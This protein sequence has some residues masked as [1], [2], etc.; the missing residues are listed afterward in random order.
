MLRILLLGSP[1]VLRDDQPV[2]I[3]RRIQRTLLFYL[4]CQ[5][6]PVGRQEL[7]ALFWPEEPDEVS[8]QR[9]REALSRLRGQLGN[10]RY[11]IISQDIVGLNPAHVS[12]DAQEFMQ[13]VAA[14]WRTLQ[15]IPNNLPLP[16]QVYQRM[17]AA[18]SLW[19]SP[20]FLAG[21][22]IHSTHEL[23]EWLTTTAHRLSTMRLQVIERL[24]YHAAAAGDLMQGI[25]WLDQ[26]LESDLLNESINTQILLWQRALGLRTQALKFCERIQTVFQRET[27][28]APPPG[29]QSL[30]RKIRE[31]TA[32]SMP[33][34]KNWP[35]PGRMQ[36]PFVG[37][38]GALQALTAAL[39]RG[40]AVL[41]SGEAG[42]GKTRLI[43]QFFQSSPLALRLLL[44]QARPGESQL[45][46]QPLIEMLRASILETE[47]RQ[48]DPIWTAALTPLLP[49]LNRL[50]PPNSPILEGQANIFE[51]LRQLLLSINADSPLLL[52]L[53]D[54]HWSDSATFDALEYL[55][56]R[57]TFAAQ[58]LLVLAARS[59]DPGPALQAFLHR[60]RKHTLETRD[61]RSLKS[62]EIADIARHILN[63]DPPEK[64]VR[65]LAHDSGGNP[66]FI[67]EILR[68][69]LEIPAADQTG[70][71]LATTSIK[72]IL[73]ERQF[74][75]TSGARLVLQTAAVIG[76]SFS[77]ELLERACALAPEQIVMAL[78][79]LERAQLIHPESGAAGAAYT[80]IHE[81][82]RDLLQK[83]LS[84]AR[85]RLL[86][87]RI[88]QILQQLPGEDSRALPAV[89][90]AH[91]EA[92][93]DFHQA[94][95]MWLK[96][97]QHA[98]RLLSPAEARNAYQRADYL[99]PQLNRQ[100]SPPVYYA[101]YSAWGD[102]ESESGN[103]PAVQRAYTEM[104]RA[105][106]DTHSSLLIGAGLSG[107]AM[108]AFYRRDLAQALDLA[109]RSLPYL[110]QSGDI[111]EQSLAL[112]RMGNALVLLNRI[113]EACAVL[114]Q[115]IDL[116][117]SSEDANIG[118]VRLTAQEWLALGLILLGWPKKAAE[119]GEQI[120]QARRAQG[121][122]SRR[123]R[124]KFT[125]ALA[126]YFHG[127]LEQGLE[128]A[129]LGID[130]A[131]QARVLRD[132]GMIYLVAA[133]NAITAGDLDAAWQYIEEGQSFAAEI[134]YTELDCGFWFARGQLLRFGK[135]EDAL[136][137]IQQ[138]LPPTPGILTPYILSDLG[139]A[140]VLSG[141]TQ[142]GLAYL[143]QA[144]Q[145]CTQYNLHSIRII[146]EILQADAL[147]ASH[148][149]QASV[150][151]LE[152]V[153]PDAWERGLRPTACIGE[154][155]LAK[156]YLEQGQW[157]AA[158]EHARLLAEQARECGARPAECAGLSLLLQA[159][160]AQNLFA[161][162]LR[163]RLEQLL[164]EM[165]SRAQLAITAACFNNFRAEMLSKLEP[166][167]E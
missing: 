94:F 52:F 68:A 49:E 109:Q 65:H 93:G 144:V 146:S 21:T 161:P 165:Q 46:F 40:G 42:A 13:A 56:E 55:L 16:V 79:E 103:I 122:V 164:G 23:D 115:A 143:E 64:L 22:K 24:S 99:L 150:E 147:H 127:K 37:R 126:L 139:H 45:P 25:Y 90:A 151:I 8:R 112:T 148:R 76:Q 128:I 34:P 97:A 156:F 72:N 104:R 63:Y 60:P 35:L 39:Q 17:V 1:A 15:Q 48:L 142:M 20:N 102:L 149:S 101:L 11:W 5:P 19:R 92:G 69:W 131:R 26:V 70:A 29:L 2:V 153:L 159:L 123:V 30:C 137:A 78:E 53:D 38:T 14:D 125:Q 95:F 141:S 158:A 130:T 117:D 43:Q 3:R 73:H 4:A 124:A 129:R 105:G 28:A 54:A 51:A 118:A 133:L 84:P 114:Q 152:R 121:L 89:V 166:Q 119:L 132:G 74:R 111:L 167:S 163:A 71:L 66:L 41:I 81:I 100:L 120:I 162:E 18:V 135:M 10:P 134:D 136:P 80:F 27:G 87:L 138:A 145:V 110:R 61:L 154:K 67:I 33:A 12:V 91:F 113:E 62:D 44:A 82:F 36:V 108:A 50:I 116:C 59:E 47:W 106:E 96:S 85:R 160:R 32:N 6:H 58:S 9:L 75:L 7:M 88:A 86:H 57:D 155:I 107:L 98:R 157:A 83:E 77:V 31:E 140:L